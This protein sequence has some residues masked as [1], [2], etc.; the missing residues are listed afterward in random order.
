MPGPLAGT[1]V[2]EL[3]GRGPGP[4]G[5]M[6]LLRDHGFGDDE[7]AALLAAGAVRQAAAAPERAGSRE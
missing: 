5:A 4:F 3:Q 7:V 2:V 1:K 6:L